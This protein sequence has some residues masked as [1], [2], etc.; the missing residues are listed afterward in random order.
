MKLNFTKAFLIFML[1]MIGLSNVILAQ[2][3]TVT[4]PSG[5]YPVNCFAYI[6]YNFFAGLPSSQ[7]VRLSTDN[8]TTWTTVNTGLTPYPS[9]ISFAVIGT[10]LFAIDCGAGSNPFGAIY[11]TANNG[12]SWAKIPATDF[13]I[14]YVSS[15]VSLG[16]DLYAAV[17]GGGGI[18]KSSDNGSTW[19]QVGAGTASGGPLLVNGTTIYAGL[20]YSSDNGTTWN[21]MKSPPASAWV[22]AVIGTNFFIGDNSGKG[23]FHTSNNGATWTIDTLGLSTLKIYSMIANGSDLYVGTYGAGVFKSTNQGAKWVADNSGVGQFSKI[24]NSFGKSATDLFWSSTNTVYKKSVAT[25]VEEISFS[26]SLNI[27]PNPSVGRFSL[28][29]KNNAQINSIEISN[30]IGE[31]ILFQQ[32]PNEIDLSNAPKGIY[33]ANISVEGK[34]CIKK[35]IVQ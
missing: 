6:G 31:R 9:I 5:N 10:T 24:S 12:T 11:M 19:K 15:I 7:G 33:F 14:S 35:L 13:F 3:K 2:W 23:V 1:A 26:E 28:S 18:Y 25:K 27:F 22:T 21:T 30:I 34:S 4:P 8:G 16:N 32:N 29:V 20:N 17:T